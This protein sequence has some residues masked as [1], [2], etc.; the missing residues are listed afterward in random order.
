MKKVPYVIAAMIA[1][2][3][4]ALIAGVTASSDSPHPDLLKISLF[5]GAAIRFH[6]SRET[7]ISEFGEPDS[8]E[9]VGA[10]YLCY[11]DLP[12]CGERAEAVFVIDQRTDRMITF[13]ARIPC[14]T[15]EEAN[16]LLPRIKEYVKSQ[17]PVFRRYFKTLEY[18]NPTDNFYFENQFAYYFSVDKM[19]ENPAENGTGQWCVEVQGEGPEEGKRVDRVR[20][21]WGIVLLTAIAVAAVS[22]ICSRLRKRLTH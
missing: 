21:A 1:V 20:K 5:D 2:A 12:F 8:V 16:D 9:V 4:L 13:N 17:Y 7:V 18:A 11:R 10:E 6:A 14:E 15:K 3:V 19:V 22:L